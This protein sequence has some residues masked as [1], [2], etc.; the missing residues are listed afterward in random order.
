M[1][2]RYPRTDAQLD[3]L[4]EKHLQTAELEQTTRDG[5]DFNLNKHIRPLIGSRKI[6]M[7]N[8][9]MLESFN[10][11]LRRCRDHCDGRTTLN[12]YTEQPHR[13]GRRC[14]KHV[15]RPLSNV[16][17]RKINFIIS[18][19]YQ[20]AM[21]WEGISHNPVPNTKLPAAP[22]PARSHP[23]RRRPRGSC[24]RPGSTTTTSAH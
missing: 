14:R 17:I 3:V 4:I 22:P 20:G 13:C 7:I 10:A 1:S 6:S 21:C 19:T 18:G 2:N 23:P 8:V 16:T 12:H 11:E 24:P 9:E 5:Y 15:C